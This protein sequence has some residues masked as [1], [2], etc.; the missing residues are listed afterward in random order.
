MLCVHVGTD[1]EKIWRQFGFVQWVDT[2][3]IVFQGTAT[4]SWYRFEDVNAA[5]IT[6]FIL[7]DIVMLTT[8]VISLLVL[9]F[10][11]L[12]QMW[13]ASSSKQ[14]NSS[15]QQRKHS[16]DAGFAS[17]YH[18]INTEPSQNF[19]EANIKD[20]DLETHSE[21]KIRRSHFVQQP[22]SS[23]YLVTTWNFTFIFLLWLSGVCTASVLNFPYFISS[24]C[25]ALCWGLHLNRTRCFLITQII[26]IILITLY[27]FIHL[28]LLYVY[29]LQSVQDLVPRPSITARCVCV[30]TCAHV[31]ACPV[32]T[33]LSV[34]MSIMF[35]L[36]T[37]ILCNLFCLFVSMLTYLHVMFVCLCM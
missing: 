17:N 7:P 31:S 12:S 18:S 26:V 36:Y 13:E 21:R 25:L 35:S 16:K 14:A 20:V 30:W 5:D 8:S 32:C 6:R 23:T 22:T 33:Y 27:S 34:C 28:I 19:S 9:M 24:V 29:Q 4:L 3:F 1:N 37:V 10:I 11:A 2:C 15:Q